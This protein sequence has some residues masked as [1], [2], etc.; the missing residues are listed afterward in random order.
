MAAWAELLRQARERAGLSQREM[1]RRADVTRKTIEKYE[2]GTVKRPVRAQLVNLA[3]ALELGPQQLNDVLA[4]AGFDPEPVGPLASI[5]QRRPAVQDMAGEVASYPWPCLVLNERYEVIGWNQPANVVAELDFGRALPTKFERNLMRIAALPHFFNGRIVNWDQIM[6]AMVGLYKHREVDVA[7]AEQE[8]AYFARLVQELAG[9]FPPAMAKFMQLWAT[10]PSYGDRYRLRF[11]AE[12]RTNDGTLLHFNCICYPWSD[13]DALWTFDWFPADGATWQWLG[14]QMTA[15]RAPAPAGGQI[16]LGEGSWHAMLRAARDAS[17]ISRDEVARLSGV[18]V[19]TQDKYER[20][21]GNPTRATLMKLAQGLQL[22]TATTNAILIAAGK[23]PVPSDWA[24]ILTGMPRQ[25]TAKLFGPSP[26]V[27][28]P[29]AEVQIELDEY[30]WPSLLLDNRCELA[31]QNRLA[32]RL[33]GMG[34]RDGAFH[35]AP[36]NVITFALSRFAREHLVNW[37]EVASALIPR[38]IRE[39]AVGLGTGRVAAKVRA[40]VTELQRQEPDAMRHLAELWQQTSPPPLT[41]RASF[42]WVWKTDGGDVLSFHAIVCWLNYG[43]SWTID[44]HPADGATWEWI[45][46]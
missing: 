17:E 5:A 42:P 30:P 34:R 19:D 15:V 14:E 20:G 44:L 28:R 25:T 10:A 33:L 29:L 1:A 45:A 13:F 21:Q 9:H 12:W 6:S 11:P 43:E 40:T 32:A 7:N 46:R 41:A 35:D 18:S 24:L 8:S 16:S 31:G 38:G 26:R 36:R 2:S 23:P 37:E 39:A 22:D 27:S 3:R 4:A